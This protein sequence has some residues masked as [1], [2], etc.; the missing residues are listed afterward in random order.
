MLQWWWS[1][2][3]NNSQQRFD[4]DITL[5]DKYLYASFANR[6][7][8]NSTHQSMLRHDFFPHI[9]PSSKQ[10]IIITNEGADIFTFM[11]L[12]HSYF[13]Y[14][15]QASRSTWLYLQESYY[16]KLAIILQSCPQS[17]LK[18]N[19][20]YLQKQTTT[21]KTLWNTTRL[22]AVSTIDIPNQSVFVLCC[23]IQTE[24]C[25]KSLF[26][27]LCSWL[28]MNREILRR[29]MGLWSSEG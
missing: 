8:I 27:A 4:F 2:E 19:I 1:C 3:K 24:I 5:W 10:F 20:Q 21:K 17:D 14:C 6:Q 28:T 15:A 7:S 12:C 25:T 23:Q 26:P 22:S 16:L 29:F 13:Q 9:Q 11:D 18:D